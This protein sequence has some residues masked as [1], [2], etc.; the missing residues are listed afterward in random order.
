METFINALVSYFVII[1]PVG[2]ALIF[3]GLTAGRDRPYRRKM[4][5]KAVALSAAIVLL[6][7]FFG[8]RFLAE[9]GIAIDSFRIAGGLLL[10]YT[11]FCMV[12]RPGR[13]EQDFQSRDSDDISVY[14]LT[15]PLIAGPGCLTLTILLFSHVRR[16]GG[17]LVWL[18][19]AV[20]AVY[21]L[22]LAAFLASG[23]V[24]R[25][26]GR[27]GNSILKRLLGVLL[28]ALSVQY[29]ADGLKGL[30]DS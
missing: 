22:T 27:T 6:F 30:L 19:A 25:L 20:A 16:S 11:A 1:D 29:I 4:A 2:M 14:P 18:A 23:P 24:S 8:A 7:G 26:F 10:F 17:N 13:Q 12:T 15:I 5:L 3:A 28:A 9:L 21:A